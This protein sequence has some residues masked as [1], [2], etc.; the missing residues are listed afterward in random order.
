MKRYRNRA[1]LPPTRR[2][3]NFLRYLHGHAGGAGRAS[4]YERAFY[5][6]VRASV[7]GSPRPE[8][9]HVRGRDGPHHAY[10]GVDVI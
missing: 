8:A 3:V 9:R 2:T 10:G 5:G 6:C 4:V 1:R 7:N